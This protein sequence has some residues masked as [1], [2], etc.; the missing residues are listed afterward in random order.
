[1]NF[2]NRFSWLK[3]K[4]FHSSTVSSANNNTNNNSNNS[5]TSILDIQMN[6]DED[7][8]NE[9]CLSKL[10]NFVSYFLNLRKYFVKFE[11]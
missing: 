11:R 8:D 4:Y 2:T 6:F 10:F 5:T 1:M 7:N 9:T 3:H